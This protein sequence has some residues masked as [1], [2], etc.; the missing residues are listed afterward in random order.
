MAQTN[1]NIKEPSSTHWG[2]KWTRQKLDAFIDYV[3]AYLRIMR[4]HPYWQTVYF[5]GFA[6]SGECLKHQETRQ[7][8]LNLEFE[9]E[10]PVGIDLYKGSV[11]RILELKELTFD[12]YYFIDSNPQNISQIEKI[13]EEISHIDKNRIITRKDNCNNQIPKWR[14]HY[15]LKN[16]LP[17]CLLIPLECRWIGN[18]LPV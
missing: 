12:Y 8:R 6:G 10:A 11:R 18:P 15:G 2:G 16:L 9:E 5:D 4:Y 7:S 17:F 3:K 13:K 1:S 14:K